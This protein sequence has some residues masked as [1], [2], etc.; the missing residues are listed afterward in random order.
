MPVVEWRKMCLCCSNYAQHIDETS[1]LMW[2]PSHGKYP[3]WTP[4]APFVQ[5]KGRALNDEA[6]KAAT[7]LLRSLFDSKEAKQRR[8]I[9]FQVRKRVQCLLTYH[10][11]ALQQLRIQ[12]GLDHH[13]SPVLKQFDERATATQPKDGKLEERRQGRDAWTSYRPPPR[14]RQQTERGGRPT[15]F[16]WYSEVS[17]PEFRPS[18]GR[19]EPY[20]SVQQIKE[21][22]ANLKPPPASSGIM[23]DHG[24]YWIPRSC[25]RH[26]EPV[27]A[28][29]ETT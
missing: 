10:S 9:R 16:L 27:T 3:T 22:Q 13:A 26:V 19:A 14:P 4:E 5:A 28:Q 8:G 17:M 2:V 12:A 24:G 25:L 1:R 11:E 29:S 7:R 21:R 15:I 6:D 23:V 20:L 18:T